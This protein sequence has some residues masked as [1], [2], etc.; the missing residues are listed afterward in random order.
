MMLLEKIFRRYMQPEELR[1]AER[2]RVLK[3][4]VAELTQR[5]EQQMVDYDTLLNGIDTMVWLTYDPERQG[6]ANEAFLKFFKVRQEDIE[7]K[8]LR[9]MMPVEEAEKCIDINR[10]VF[11]TGVP[12]TSYEWV[13]RHDGERRLLKINKRLKKNGST[14][15]VAS[16]EDITDLET[17]REQLEKEGRFTKSLV[18]TAH[19]LIV[20]L[21][22]KA[23]ILRCNK[24]FEEVT[25]YEFSEIKGLNWF[26]VFIPELDRPQVE[27]KFAQCLKDCQD[28]H[29]SMINPIKTKKGT[30]VLIE[31][32]SQTLLDNYNVTIGVISIGQNVTDQKIAEEALWAKTIEMEIKLKNLKTCAPECYLDGQ[33]KT[34]LLVEDEQSVLQLISLVLQ[35]QNY[36]VI[37]ASTTSKAKKIIDSGLRIDL[38]ITDFYMPGEN[39]YQLVEYAKKVLPDVKYLVTSGIVPS[40]VQIPEHN[41]LKK[42]F[43]I[44]DLNQKIAAIMGV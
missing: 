8:P 39:G 4:R 3:D 22:T 33:D 40:L 26:D 18:D 9:E 31:W 13:T 42:P 27:A 41:F 21:D 14:Y 19:A 12:H 1:N 5:I 11:K 25:G 17:I 35:K 23:N 7:N 38:I 32:F 36:T 43:Y 15:I 30:E 2:A 29:G 34:V 10:E 6:K 16:A 28:C 24:Y 20:V 44:D 37:Q